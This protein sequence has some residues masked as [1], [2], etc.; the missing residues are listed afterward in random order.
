MSYYHDILPKALPYFDSKLL[1]MTILQTPE[2]Y[3][4]N[5]NGHVP[6]YWSQPPFGFTRAWSALYLHSPTLAAHPSYHALPPHCVPA[7]QAFWCSSEHL[8]MISGFRI[9][10]ASWWNLMGH[11]S[12]HSA[13][14]AHLGPLSIVSSPRSL[15]SPFSVF[16]FTTSFFLVAFTFTQY[17]GIYWF[18]NMLF[19]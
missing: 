17:H 8:P 18:V 10:C 6:Q 16:L 4:K 9:I 14:S 1:N 5:I 15:L 13:L 2:E 11:F 12:F 3:L 19:I 7:T